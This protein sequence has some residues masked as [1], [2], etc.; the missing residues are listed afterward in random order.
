MRADNGLWWQSALWPIAFWIVTTS[1]PRIASS[2][3]NDVAQGVEAQREDAGCRLRATVAA[4]QRRVIEWTA[5]RVAE[6]KVVGAGEMLAPACTVQRR[7]GLVGER[8]PPGVPEF[9]R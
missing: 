6:H 7:R 3:P 1:I 9:R 5:E 2:E 8:H 4:A